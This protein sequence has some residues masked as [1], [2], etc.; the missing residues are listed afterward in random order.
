MQ[1]ELQALPTPPRCGCADALHVH[2]SYIVCSI[3]SLHSQGSSVAARSV[4]FKPMYPNHGVYGELFPWYKP[5]NTLLYRQAGCR[6]V[7]MRV[8][9]NCIRGRATQCP[10]LLAS[11]DWATVQLQGS[12]FTSQTRGGISFF[13]RQIALIYS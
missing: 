13:T 11:M 6:G 9:A 7:F 4:S 3:A 1:A 5:G 10:T 12:Y 2:Q 8:C